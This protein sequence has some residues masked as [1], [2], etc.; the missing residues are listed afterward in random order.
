[1]NTRKFTGYERDATGLDFANARTY[2]S[3]RGRFLQPDK[4]GL[5]AAEANRPQSFNRYTYTGNDPINFV[6]RTGLDEES[7]WIVGDFTVTINGKDSISGGIGGEMVPLD[8][9][10]LGL[11]DKEGHQTPIDPQTIL[12]REENIRESF[13]DFLKNHIS[14]DCAIALASHMESLTDRSF[15]VNLIDVDKH[16]NEYGYMFLSRLDYPIQTLGSFFDSLGFTA[17]TAVGAPVSGIYFRGSKDPFG[18]ASQYLLLHEMMHVVLGGTGD[19]DRILADRLGVVPREGE[20][21]SQAVTRYF[22]S[23]CKPEERT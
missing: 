9:P 7:W 3:E 16:E 2:A 10:T 22:N 4:L 18:G 20:N 11:P 14:S 6:D 8:S 5:G 12:D 21:F 17:L 19:L 13:R 15:T 23:M 1:M